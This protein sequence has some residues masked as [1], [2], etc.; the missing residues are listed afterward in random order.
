MTEKSPFAFRVS[1]ARA[2][3]LAAAFVSAVPA[4]AASAIRLP[5]LGDIALGNGEMVASRLTD[6]VA[7]RTG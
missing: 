5:R 3:F 6:E 1:P 7:P 2:A 4:R